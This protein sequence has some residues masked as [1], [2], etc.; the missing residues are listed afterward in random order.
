[1]EKEINYKLIDLFA[2]CGGL[3]LGFENKGFMPIFVNEINEDALSTYLRNRYHKLNGILFNQIK[4]LHLND[5]NDLDEKRIEK[6]KSDFSNFSD[7]N[8]LQEK[9]SGFTNIDVIAGG[10]PCQGY[11]GIG[12]RR[13]YNIDKQKLPSNHLYERMCFII[14]NIKP[15][16]FLFENV[17]GILNARWYQDRS[18]KIWPDVL[19]AFKSINGYIV[20]WELVY[21]KNYGIPQNRPRIIL[22]GIRED[23]IN[24]SNILNDCKD[25]DSAIKS[26]FLPTPKINVTSPDLEDLLGDLIDN[27]ILYN[28]KNAIYPKGPFKTEKYPQKALTDIQKKF[29]T[30]PD[31]LFD[32]CKFELTDHEYSKHSKKVIEKFS[33]MIENEGKI[34]DEMKTKK[35]S[36]RLLKAK[37]GNSG[38]NITATSLPDDYV[39]F[40]QPRSLTVREW[41]RI[42][43][44]PDWYQFSGKRTT[45]GLRRAG[46]PLKGQF[47]RELPKYTQIGNAVPVGLAE[48]IAEHFKLILEDTGF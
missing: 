8:F 37:W 48:A 16:I 12:H 4:D 45:G 36:Q 20:K 27:K 9:I 38:P 11:S 21:S 10:P 18:E 14:K 42:Q 33:M 41:A 5:V 39:H 30:R 46:N 43:F 47:D 17:R 2:G 1:M 7:I 3:S 32:S 35:F 34:L 26:G 22:V 29:R 40:S 23:I 15:R 31:F 28:L 6:L 13:S 44:F 25:N 19:K 24:S